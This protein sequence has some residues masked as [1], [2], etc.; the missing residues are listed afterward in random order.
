MD[1]KIL[2]LV[3]AWLEDKKPCPA[4]ESNG[5]FSMAQMKQ[6]LENNYSMEL[7]QYEIME[8]HAFLQNEGYVAS[9]MYYF[10]S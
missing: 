8:I 4:E 9:G 2:N 3:K 6:D 1:E 10:F 5:L 7:D